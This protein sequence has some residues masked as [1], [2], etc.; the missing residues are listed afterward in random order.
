[1]TGGSD[2]Q[3]SKSHGACW[4]ALTLTDARGKSLHFSSTSA[5][6]A[7]PW[8]Y[9]DVHT[10]RALAEWEHSFSNDWKSRLTLSASEHR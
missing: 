5:N 7:Q 9:W 1:M 2:D 10:T 4:G 6:I 8:V 3:H